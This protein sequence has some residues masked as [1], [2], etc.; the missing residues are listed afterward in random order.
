MLFQNSKISAKFSNFELARFRWDE[1]KKITIVIK[2]KIVF[3]IFTYLL[4]FNIFLV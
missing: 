1:F 4:T 3:L 2:K